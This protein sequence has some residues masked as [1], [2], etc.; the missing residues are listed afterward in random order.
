MPSLAR[1]YIYDNQSFINC[2][3]K[4]EYKST[5]LNRFKKAA[6]E[7]NIEVISATFMRIMITFIEF[8]FYFTELGLRKRRT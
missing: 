3:P 8:T 7:R 1:F 2:T 4:S 5:W 6:G